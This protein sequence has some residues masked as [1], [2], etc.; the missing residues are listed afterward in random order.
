M[1]NNKNILIFMW[2]SVSLSWYYGNGFMFF[3][4][5]L[6]FVVGWKK[7]NTASR[8]QPWMTMTGTSS[9]RNVSVQCA[10]WWEQEWQVLRFAQLENILFDSRFQQVD[11]HIQL[12]WEELVMEAKNTSEGHASRDEEEDYHGQFWSNMVKGSNKVFCCI[13]VCH[14]LR[15]TL[16]SQQI[17]STS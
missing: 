4:M 7:N 15:S 9:V 17:K 6:V 16:L 3:N 8:T 12:A 13:Y 1:K 10:N 14:C 2:V 11:D 5:G